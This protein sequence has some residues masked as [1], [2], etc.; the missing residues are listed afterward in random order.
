MKQP[1]PTTK[2]KS[3]DKLLNEISKKLSIIIVALLA[4]SELTEKEIADILKISEDTIE[5]MVP[6][7]KLRPKGHK[8]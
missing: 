1:N 2:E 4:R 6:F 5:R 7:K 8:E 3:T